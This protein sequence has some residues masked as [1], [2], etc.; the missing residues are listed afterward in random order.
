MLSIGR[1]LM[2]KPKLMVLDEP[3]MGLAPLVVREIF[4]IVLDLRHQGVT[5]LLVEQNARLALQLSDY[6]YVLETGRVVTH[7]ASKELITNEEV[8]KAYL[9]G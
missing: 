4:R 1:A 5:I 3:S 8:K 9:G 7:G 6:G 2:A